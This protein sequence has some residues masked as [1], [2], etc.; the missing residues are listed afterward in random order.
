MPTPD[1]LA[2]Q[3]SRNGEVAINV[4]QVTV[5]RV[6]LLL[7]CKAVELLQHYRISREHIA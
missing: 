7:C 3:V 2:C 6:R 4:K 1:E 5:W